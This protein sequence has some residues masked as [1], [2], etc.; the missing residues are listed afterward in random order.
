MSRHQRH[1]CLLIIV[2]RSTDRTDRVDI[3]EICVCSLFFDCG[4]DSFRESITQASMLHC[5][6]K[7]AAAYRLTLK[8]ELRHNNAWRR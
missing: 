7:S 1:M 3:T 2:K 6:L 4:S 8:R 5:S